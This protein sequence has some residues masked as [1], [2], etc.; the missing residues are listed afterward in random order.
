MCVITAQG[1]D[2]HNITHHKQ[3]CA[4]TRSICFYRLSVSIDYSG[5]INNSESSKAKAEKSFKISGFELDL[6]L[7]KHRVLTLVLQCI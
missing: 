1:T 5:L 3:S 4:A 2:I 7:T 6:S